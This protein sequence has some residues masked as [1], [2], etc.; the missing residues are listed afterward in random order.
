[1]AVPNQQI[2]NAAAAETLLIRDRI[3]AHH[4]VEDCYDMLNK[5][6]GL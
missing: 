4:A 5:Y 6:Q 2:K 3:S 1:V